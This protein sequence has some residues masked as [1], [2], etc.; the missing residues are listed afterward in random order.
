[1]SH[2]IS[3]S[4]INTKVKAMSSKLINKEDFEKI[5]SFENVA[6]LIAYLKNH[7]GYQDIFHQYDEH[8]VHREQAERLFIHGLYHDYTKLYRFGN[9]EQRL[10]LK[11][12][13]FRYEVNVLKACIRLIY[14]QEKMYDL[15]L[16]Y[17][18][19]SKH[20]KINVTALSSSNS[21]EEYVQNLKGT[22]YY[23]IFTRMLAKG[24]TASFDYEMQLDVYFFM[25]S[26]RLKEKM[27]TGDNR[28]AFIIRLG[29]EI[30]MN[31]IMWI[32]RSKLMYDMGPAEI[33]AYLI[34]VTY[35][36]TKSQLSRL[37][38]SASMNEFTS[39]LNDTPYKLFYHAIKNGNIENEYNKAID[40]IYKL[41]TMKYP[42][43]MSCISYHLYLKDLEIARL[44]TAI[45]CIRYHLD[46]KDKIKYILQT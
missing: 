2:S 22:K 34:P 24:I 13:F 30:D 18:F 23:P 21:I 11:L 19:F 20:S 40:K 6:D 28:K 8:E 35:Q 43:S 33:F 36:L 5:I 41:N 14:N 31:N 38:N 12:V 45:E 42:N 25:R 46:S 7:P 37:V 29:A 17:P 44:T 4:G 26:W 1:M 10:A 15:S 27:L 32:Y 16:F 3:Y 39:I 9:E